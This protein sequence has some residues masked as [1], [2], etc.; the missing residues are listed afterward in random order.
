MHLVCVCVV[1]MYGLTSSSLKAR[2]CLSSVMRVDS[3]TACVSS[4]TW[5]VVRGFPS[6][7]LVSKHSSQRGG[8]IRRVRG[9]PRVSCV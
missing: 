7:T 3:A 2:S 4:P 8:G 6:G 9:V 5:P 1:R